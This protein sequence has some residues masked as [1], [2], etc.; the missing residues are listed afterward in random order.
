MGGPPRPGDSPKNGG[1]Q[2]LSL[3]PTCAK[4]PKVRPRR[5]RQQ[6]CPTRDVA[7]TKVAP[8]WLGSG[9]KEEVV[10]VREIRQ[11]VPEE[12]HHNENVLAIERFESDAG[13]YEQQKKY[14]MAAECLEQAINLRRKFLGDMHQD[15]LAA[16][17]RYVVSC[18][19][20]GIQCLN[21]GQ[22]TS[23]LEL[24]KKAE[25]MTEEKNVPNF[26]R[27]V[28]LRAATFNNLCCYFRARGKLNAALQFAEKALKIEQRYKDAENPART[29]LNYAVLL[30]MMN[31]HE[32]SV[33]H[34]ESAIAILHDDERQI[35]YEHTKPE[36]SGANAAGLREQQHLEVVSV[37]VVAYYNMWVEL[38][39]LSRREAGIDCILRAANIAKRKLGA[40][41]P[42]TTKMEETLSVVQ[43]QLTK[44]PVLSHAIEAADTGMS[45][46]THVDRTPFVLPNNTTNGAQLPPL[47]AR[48]VWQGHKTNE[49]AVKI[50]VES[51]QI[52]SRFAPE[53][54]SPPRTPG[55]RAPLPAGLKQLRMMEHVYG[56]STHPIPAET[57]DPIFDSRPKL[58]S[59]PGYAGSAMLQQQAYGAQP[60]ITA[61]TSAERCRTASTADPVSPRSVCVAV[62]AASTPRP[63]LPMEPKPPA[64]APASQHLRA[65]YTF[66]MKQAQLRESM[67]GKDPE[68]P[69]EPDRIR[70]IGV[71]RTRIAQRRDR[72]LPTPTDSRRAQ[73]ALQ[74]QAHY[75]G[76]LVRQWSPAELARELKRQ[77][78]VRRTSSAQVAE[79]AGDSAAAPHAGVLAPSLD[80][81]ADM[82]R[83][84]AFRVVYAARRAFVEYSAAVKV[85]KTWRGWVAR[86]DIKMEIALVADETAT[87]LQALFRRYSAAALFYRC[88][89]MATAIQSACRQ[90]LARRRVREMTRFVR[91]LTR[92]A[93]GHTTRMHLASLKQAAV[94][95]Q[96]T[97]RS[98]LA[99]RALQE[100]HR[101]ALVVQRALRG[102][103]ARAYR[104]KV[105][106]AVCRISALW[107]GH[108]TRKEANKKNAAARCIQTQYRYRRVTRKRM[109]A[110]ASKIGASWR[111]YRMRKNRPYRR[112]ACRIQAHMR[113]VLVREG[114]RKMPPSALRIQASWRSYRVRYR[115]KTLVAL[116]IVLQKL[117]RRHLASRQLHLV[118][119]AVTNCQR[120]ARGFRSRKWLR[121]AH[122]SA[123]RL[124]AFWRSVSLRRHV[125]KQELAAQRI[126]TRTRSVFAWRRFRAGRA[127]ARVIQ[128]GYSAYCVRKRTRSTRSGMSPVFAATLVISA[129]F[130]GHLARKDLCGK[131][132]AAT[133]VQRAW[134]GHAQRAR[135][136]RRHLAAARI[137]AAFRM[138]RQQA[139]Y[140]TFRS[141]AVVFAQKAWRKAVAI[142]AY[143][144]RRRLA[145]SL[146]AARRSQTCRRDLSNAQR[147]SV[148]IQST[149]RRYR[150]LGHA[151]LSNRNA[152]KLQAM[153]VGALVRAQQKR[154]QGAAVAMQRICRGCFMR[155]RFRRRAAAWRITI[156]L[157]ARLCRLRYLRAREAAVV[158][159][160]FCRGRWARRHF[161]G[162]RK[163]VN[164]VK[165]RRYQR[166]VCPTLGFKMNLDYDKLTASPAMRQEVEATIKCELLTM[167]ANLKEDNVI[168]VLEKG[169]VVVKVFINAPSEVIKDL[170][171]DNMATSSAIAKHITSK[172]GDVDG[173]A[174]ITV[175][176]KLTVMDTAT[177]EVGQRRLAAARRLQRT[178]RGAAVRLRL[179]ARR[180]A[181]V[182]I[183]RYA[184]G[185]L[186]RRRLALL[187]QLATRLRSHWRRKVQQRRYMKTQQ[188]CRAV[189]W[190]MR[191]QQAKRLVEKGLRQPGVKMVTTAKMLLVRRK[192]VGE[193]NAA[194]CIQRHVRGHLARS[195]V[196]FIKNVRPIALQNLY[197]QI[198]SKEHVEHLRYLAHREAMRGA[199]MRS[200]RLERRRY[201]AATRIQ[202]CQRM[203]RHRRRYQLEVRWALPKIQALNRMFLDR[204]D[205]R[206]QLWA[207][208]VIQKCVRAFCTARLT[209]QH[210]AASVIQQAFRHYL[211]CSSSR[212]REFNDFSAL[213]HATTVIQSSWR[214]YNQVW[215]YKRI[216]VAATR[217]QAT[218]RA[219]IK[220]LRWKGKV[221]AAIRIQASGVLPWIAMQ[222]LRKRHRRLVQLQAFFRRVLVRLKLRRMQSA[223]LA[224]Q[225]AWRCKLCHLLVINRREGAA[226]LIQSNVRLHYQRRVAYP[227]RKAALRSIQAHSRGFLV[228]KHL[229]RQHV[230][231]NQ[232]QQRFRLTQ[233]RHSMANVNWLVLALQRIFRG[234]RSRIR[235]RWSFKK[236]RRVPAR[237]RGMQ[238]RSILWPRF[239]AAAT[240]IQ[241]LF[242]GRQGRL[243]HERRMRAAIVLQ[244]WWRRYNTHGKVP[245]VRLAVHRIQRLFRLWQSTL[246][247]RALR[248]L[249]AR[250]FSAYIVAGPIEQH[251][252]A[253]RSTVLIQRAIRGALHR[254]QVSKLQLSARRIQS[255]ARGFLAWRN[256]LKRYRALITIQATMH[257]RHGRRVYMRCRKQVIR[258][259]A[260]MKM[261]IARRRFL[262][263]RGAQVH[264]SRIFRGCRRRR[265]WARVRIACL[266][267]QRNVR[268]LV[269]RS[270]YHGLLQAVLR[271]QAVWHGHVARAALRNR[272]AGATKIAA[273]WRAHRARFRYSKVSRI[274]D[275]IIPTA[276][277]RRHMRLRRRKVAGATRI[278]AAWRGY[279]QRHRQRRSEA[280]WR[281]QR[282]WRQYTVWQATSDIS[283]ELLVRAKL[284]QEAHM[285][286]FAVTIQRWYRM[287]RLRPIPLRRW[288][289]AFTRLQGHVRRRNAAYEVNIHRRVQGVKLKRFICRDRI[290]ERDSLGRLTRSRE[291]RADSGQATGV[292]V[293]PMV[294]LVNLLVAQRAALSDILSRLQ[295]Y[296]R[297]WISI[298]RVVRI[299]RVWRG[300]LARRDL[301]TKDAAAI[302]IQSMIRVFL[303][304]RNLQR[305]RKLVPLAQAHMRRHLQQVKDNKLRRHLQQVKDNK[306]RTLRSRGSFRGRL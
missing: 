120:Y 2:G 165:A 53:P 30:S 306:P 220:R 152:T 164:M 19:L 275:L 69:L 154:E 278:A 128:S 189:T 258:L 232:I 207:T 190:Y 157:A 163:F 206:V 265:W 215:V 130:R 229:A 245:L 75:R 63:L 49:S 25:L 296:A 135:L 10:V 133:E 271:I 119:V 124:Q 244:A 61:R 50:L 59:I 248:S 62:P 92:I 73:A 148:C 42:L 45:E 238:W 64:E 176:E 218:A 156:W 21:S 104:A 213:V 129:Y 200:Q 155:R 279:S 159:Q 36:D 256:T 291:M 260:Y 80:G 197:R 293:I 144:A 242:R 292:R 84:V 14:V 195:R 26:K 137:Q 131:H 227:R 18:N 253:K 37:L 168:V 216:L 281:I 117:A 183:Q 132:H 60:L 228:Q 231:A 274:A 24:L 4:L 15:F 143:R 214:R 287:V 169:S 257:G 283:V 79:E 51:Q 203:R 22:Y 122:V 13:P 72:G 57:S 282:W 105:R 95:L 269:V 182:T 121:L 33:E 3:P 199:Q 187:G 162:L 48:A 153:V 58:E 93:Y 188:V 140:L 145:A 109:H 142:R 88:D 103:T 305:I 259:Q 286:H 41:H 171:I 172:V 174:S 46:M 254:C 112:S 8:I 27:R 263:A 198:K 158:L 186:A 12:M 77:D 76:Y 67:D 280:A 138:L 56:R 297:Y 38:S 29:H 300:H 101:G 106:M 302:K 284:M 303:C 123:T 111:G 301:Q 233:L 66:H 268:G 31:R 90:W 243:R 170:G 230:A 71:F 1:L 298:C 237:A 81:P 54:F 55:E 180:E 221:D 299:Q 289:K 219:F 277:R 149:W 167:F 196:R 222:R 47:D 261:W 150:H 98:F 179:R 136:R 191:T 273:S 234:R 224:I 185:R 43:E 223:A 250:C 290:L 83:R 113:G 217:I 285:T 70:A 267:I 239:T 202:A 74:I 247:L 252:S 225:A 125:I 262:E 294:D 126:Q 20:F 146:Q 34:I 208:I 175:G 28:S 32:E 181:C 246:Q 204:E 65:A 178:W 161:L 17:E 39:R 9:S 236:L 205:Y 141:A 251:A 16:V 35:S 7:A 82:K 118:T 210:H 151:Q 184:R 89:C 209:K 211:I 85:Q 276:W 100:G 99:R 295:G 110:A 5:A 249:Y 94:P 6:P 87:K 127:A 270:W 114:L 264:I 194:I 40:V 255:S 44:G 116:G 173:I 11:I 288:R 68:V 193:K 91:L 240:V 266:V 192:V 97:I 235:T 108:A 23:S 78:H 166:G 107:R 212:K 134:R 139:C 96:R 201:E 272:K 115:F 147:A 160:T 52:K 177:A 86:R 226:V 241:R 304:R 102:W